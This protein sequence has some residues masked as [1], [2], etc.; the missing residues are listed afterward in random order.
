[1]AK[2]K[3]QFSWGELYALGVVRMPPVGM[4]KEDIETMM[5]WRQEFGKEKFDKFVD[6]VVNTQKMLSDINKGEK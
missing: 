6:L 2:S 1:M 4:T 3:R 5:T